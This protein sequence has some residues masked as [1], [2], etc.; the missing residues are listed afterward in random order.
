MRD[1]LTG[2]TAIFQ[3]DIMLPA[4]LGPSA[5]RVALD[6]SHRLMVAVFEDALEILQK[7]HAARD[8][9]LRALFDE[10]YE[11]F[12]SDDR[13]WPYA[14][15]NVCEVLRLDPAYVRFGIQR[16]LDTHREHPAG[17]KRATASPYR[18]VA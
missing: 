13:E 6:P 1:G 8:A 17:H 10:T 9:K 5:R 3:P 12:F 7:H 11:W 2:D 18:Q 15:L 16:W 4:Q 14:F